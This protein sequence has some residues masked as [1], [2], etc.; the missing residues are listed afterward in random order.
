ML[1]RDVQAHDVLALVFRA[2][3]SPC[4]RDHVL[5]FLGLGAHARELQGEAVVDASARPLR[6]GL[7]HEAVGASARSRRDENDASLNVVARV[8]VVARANVVARVNVAARSSEREL[9]RRA[10]L[11]SDLNG[12]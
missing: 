7:Y 5:E 8:N 11:G 1:A 9:T 10:S 6:R 3:E 4:Q 12:P 2:Y